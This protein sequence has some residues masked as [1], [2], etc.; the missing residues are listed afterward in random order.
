MSF[1]K[2]YSQQKV[3]TALQKAYSLQKIPHAYIFAGYQGVGKFTTARQW[4]KLL[5]CRNPQIEKNGSSPFAD[6]CNRC[7]SCRLFEANSHP[8]LN[9]VHKELL[10]YTRNGK[11]KPDPRDLRIDVI[12]EFLIQKAPTKPILSRRK[13]FIITEAE[14]LSDSSQNALMKIL[15]EPP[16][17][18]SII[19]LCT[20]MEKLLPTTKSRCQVIRFSAVDEEII[21]DELKQKNL[22]AQK[23]KFFARLSNG[24]LGLACRWADLEIN[25]AQLYKIKTEIINEIA[26]YELPN[27][28]NLA[29]KCLKNAKTIT[30]IW[31]D[32]EK[33]TSK[34]DLKRKAQKTVIQIITSAFRDAMKINFEKPE[35]FINFDQ[36]RK[37]E[38]ISSRFA[39]ENSA[40]KIASC[41]RAVRWIDANVNE[42]LIFEHLL[43]NLNISDKIEAL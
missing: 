35:Q 17:F 28:L 5:L 41:C 32:L 43:L 30:D 3:I 38:K 14:K 10:E 21:T 36:K 8:D 4:A 23:A 11:N 6:S 33:N 22:E 34:T 20:R 7:E 26:D 39:P 29:Q 9:I 25:N 2:I 19:L 42:K 37:I 1:K 16:E 27:A 24:S 18:C 12:R 15:E 31:S 13:I 40:E